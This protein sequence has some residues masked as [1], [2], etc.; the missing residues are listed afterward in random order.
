M[1]QSRSPAF[2]GAYGGNLRLVHAIHFRQVDLTKIRSADCDDVFS[3]QDLLPKFSLSAPIDLIEHVFGGRPE[4]K[5]IWVTTARIVAF[6]Q[7][8]QRARIFPIEDFP[9]QPVA[10]VNPAFASSTFNAGH[11]L[12]LF[13]ARNY[14]P[15]AGKMRGLNSQAKI[16]ISVLLFSPFPWPAFRLRALINAGFDSCYLVFSQIWKW[17]ASMG[18]HLDSIPLREVES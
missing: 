5:M 13:I 17:V 12:S 6:M 15:W 2:S 16:S 1:R 9:C 14:I 3:R 8:F 4:V 11:N 7:N 18:F 10:A